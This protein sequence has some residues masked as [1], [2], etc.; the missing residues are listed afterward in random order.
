[1]PTK[2]GILHRW[3]IP[4]FAGMTVFIWFALLSSALAHEPRRTIYVFSN[5]WHSAIVVA[6]A[7]RPELLPPEAEDFP[8]S[9][10]LE[11]GWGDRE[12]YTAPQPTIAMH[13]RAAFGF[14]PSV[15]YQAGIALAPKDFYKDVTVTSIVVTEAV[16]EQLLKT[17]NAGF[18]RQGATRVQPLKEQTNDF[19]R[20]YPGLGSFSL[21]NTCN[22]WVAKTLEAAGVG[23]SATAVV[24]SSQ[25]M[26]RVTALPTAAV[27]A[28]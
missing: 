3:K 19:G 23:I 22:T 16:Y 11:Y 24:T 26:D 21:A 27:M 9:P 6:R 4:A 1:M 15:I 10:F 17:I 13:V 5:G 7:D 28:Q 14:G 12:F 8:L 25:L 18:D 20:F 2:V